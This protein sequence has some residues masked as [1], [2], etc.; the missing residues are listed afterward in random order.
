MSV[1]DA[2]E[3]RDIAMICV[4]CVKSMMA[5]NAA[6]RSMVYGAAL[7][8]PGRSR[9]A[10]KNAMISAKRN[11]NEFK[12]KTLLSDDEVVPIFLKIRD[13][14]VAMSVAITRSMY[15]ISFVPFTIYCGFIIALLNDICYNRNIQKY[16]KSLQGDFY[17]NRIHSQS[18]GRKCRDL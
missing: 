17:E 6:A 9:P 15:I 8:M 4:T 2:V 5:E 1:V 7:T 3:P 13:L 18:Y 10:M 12:R 16:N 14:L 11:V